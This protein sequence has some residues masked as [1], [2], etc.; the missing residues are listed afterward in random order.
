MLDSLH[1]A[2]IENI[3]SGRTISI[4]VNKGFDDEFTLRT[5][6]SSDGKKLAHDIAMAFQD[7][8]NKAKQ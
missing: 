1:R 5:P 4:T 8:F 3:R 2:F 6:P 7:Y